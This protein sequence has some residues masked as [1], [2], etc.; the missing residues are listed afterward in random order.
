MILHDLAEFGCV[1]LSLAEFGWVLAEFWLD[2][3]MIWLDL[4]EFGGV[5]L[6]FL[7]DLA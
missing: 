2:F 5:W 6:F 7:H 1:W 3:G 4:A